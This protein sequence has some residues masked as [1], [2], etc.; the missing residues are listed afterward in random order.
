MWGQTLPSFAV[1]PATLAGELCLALG[2]EQPGEIGPRG[3]RLSRPGRVSCAWRLQRRAP[4]VD[5]KCR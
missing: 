3:W 4:F 2:H 5:M 1:S